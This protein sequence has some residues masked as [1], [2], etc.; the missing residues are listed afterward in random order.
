MVGWFS[1]SGLDIPFFWGSHEKRHGYI[2]FVSILLTFFLFSL[3]SDKRRYYRASLIVASVVAII[4]IFEYIGFSLFL[5]ELS[6]QSW[7]AGRS[8]STLGNPN[9][10]A[11]YLLMHLPF[12]YLIRQSERMI[13]VLLLVFGILTTGSMIGMFLLLTYGIIRYIDRKYSTIV[14]PFLLGGIIISLFFLP[15]EKM[16]SFESRFILM[17]ETLLPLFS[18]VGHFLFGYGPDAMIQHF[19]LSRDMLLNAYF[20]SN[21]NIDSSL[22]VFIDIAFQYGFII[23][24][25]LIFV[26][27]RRYRHLSD[28][29]RQAFWLGS[30]FFSLNVIV[31]APLLIFVIILSYGGKLEK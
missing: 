1:F 19:S 9:Y 27:V 25:G 15:H 5:P 4:A 8:V 28:F 2:F 23:L 29:E 18:G 31:L 12:L 30:I 10:V 17:Y 24:S 7:G 13:L 6:K 26:L 21:M 20:P 11:G 22:N 3:V 16:L 14:L